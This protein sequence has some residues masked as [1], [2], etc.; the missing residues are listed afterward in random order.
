MSTSS[1]IRM[2]SAALWVV[3]LAVATTAATVDP[4]TLPPPAGVEVDFQR[5]IQPILEA[6]CLRCHGPERPKSGYRLDNRADALREGSYDRPIIPGDSGASALIHYVAHAVEEME[7]PPPAKAE[8]LTDAQV[9]LLRAWIDQGM[10]WPEPPAA[11]AWEAE[12]VPV[13]GWFWVDG[14]KGRFREHHWVNDEYQVGLESFTMRERIDVDTD[15]LVT[16][17]ALREDYA[18]TLEWRRREAGFVRGGFEQFRRYYDDSGGYYEPFP[19]QEFRLDQDLALDLGKAFLEAGLTRPGLPEVVVGYEYLYRDGDKSILQ[20][21]PSSQGGVVRD[22]RPNAK[23][24]DEQVHVARAD[25]SYELA[26]VMLE[27]NFRYEFYDLDTK[28]T[29]AL[30]WPADSNGSHL[31][32]EEGT[33]YHQLANSFSAESALRD[34]FLVSGGYLYTD[35]GGDASFRQAT[36]DTAGQPTPGLYWSGNEI[37]L[38]QRS[39]TAN[40]NAQW[41]PWGGVIM[42]AGVQPEWSRQRGFGQVRLDQGLPPVPGGG[43]APALIQ[44]DIDRFLIEERAGFRVSSLPRTSLFGEARLRQESISQFEESAGSTSG[45]D[46]DFVRDTEASNL[47]QDYLG[48][49]HVSP[50]QRVSLTAHYRKRWKEND[51]DHDLDQNDLGYAYSAFITGQK[52]DTDEI[53]S[54]LVVRPAS[55]L[56]TTFTYRLESTDYQTRTDAVPGL[57]PG[58]WMGDAGV[59]DAQLFGLGMVLTPVRRLY[60]STS[61]TYA[62]TRTKTFANGD[63]AIVP[64]EGDVYTV[65]V[66]G[67]YAVNEQTDVNVAYNVSWADYEQH[68]GAAG[69]PVGERY[70]LHTVLGGLTRRWNERLTGRLQY[71]FYY[72]DEPSA[73]GANDYVAHGFLASL[74]LRLP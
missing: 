19:I 31:G 46:P 10:V 42:Y 23:A 1:S 40:A 15:V 57:T 63:P 43:V 4:A 68:N 49:V 45:F 69:L 27:D 52:F 26:G 38:D 37:T 71:G 17:R 59:H 29:G 51:Y 8:R 54:K 32:I 28:R 18:V 11:P 5:D 12:V 36:V 70:D 30:P 53:E 7:M 25:L 50:W 65:L 33:D 21:L 72:Y 13:M 56:K 41:G 60:L 47:L 74:A 2:L 9:G 61:A 44:S 58:G 16:G 39:H 55:W 48:G 3:G 14:D 62:N 67:A 73:G 66:S 22:I 64:Y 24:I 34:W 20:W 6:S 35:L